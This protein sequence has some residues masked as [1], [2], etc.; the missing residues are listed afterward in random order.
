MSSVP[1]HE[2]ADR[3]M[4]GYVALHP[5]YIFGHF[6]IFVLVPKLW[7]GNAG[8]QAPACHCHRNR[9]QELPKPGSQ[10]GAWEPEQA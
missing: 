8:R 4:V 2:N 7:F 6:I 9:K 10:A 5:P 1:V 3:G